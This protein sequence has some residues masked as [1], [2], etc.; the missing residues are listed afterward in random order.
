[1]REKGIISTNQYIWLL[2]CIITSFTALNAPTL[3][4]FQSGRD[5]WLAVIFAWFMDVLLAVV[6]AYMGIRFPGQNM[7]QYS[8]TILGKY[9]GKIVGIVFPV[10]FLLVSAFIQRSLSITLNI[11][12]FQK[13][14][15]EVNLIASYIVIGYAALKGIEVIGRVCEILGPIY[16]LSMIFLFLFVIPDVQIGQ[17][18]PQLEHGIYPA[19]PAR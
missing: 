19:F 15:V 16:F 14:P 10:Y 9:F 1:M 3:L 5:S 8:M 7:T 17:L 18:K 13:T 4:I 2:F 6:Y 12:F 11:I